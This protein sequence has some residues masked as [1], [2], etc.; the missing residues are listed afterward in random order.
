MAE[1]YPSYHLVFIP[2]DCTR[3]AQPADVGLQRPFKLLE[4]GIA[5]C[6]ESKAER[7]MRRFRTSEKV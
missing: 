5:D 1:G 3:K 7:E 4:T 6:V 2:A